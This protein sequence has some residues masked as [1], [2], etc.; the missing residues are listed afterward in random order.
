MHYSSRKN[1]VESNIDQYIN[2]ESEFPCEVAV[3]PD[4]TPFSLIRNLPILRAQENMMGLRR[5]SLEV[6]NDLSRCS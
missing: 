4:Y 5:D 6:S 1:V 3:D 2:V